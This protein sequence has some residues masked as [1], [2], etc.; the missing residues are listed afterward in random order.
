MPIESKTETPGQFPQTLQIRQHSL[1]ADVNEQLG[2]TD[3]APDPHD[4]FDAALIA[5]KTLTATWFAKR[6]KIALERVEAQVERDESEER[7]GRYVLKVRIAFF[8][9]LNDEERAKLY[10]AVEKCPV[11]KLMTSS[12]VVIETEPLAS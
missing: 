9:D 1:R 8:G 11:H 12:E 5:C 3:S 6:Y 2:S 4:Y 10:A 7:K